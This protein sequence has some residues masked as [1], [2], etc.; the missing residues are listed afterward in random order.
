MNLPNLPMAAVDDLEVLDGPT[1]TAL[2]L[3]P[4]GDQTEPV[5]T[6]C[7]WNIYNTRV[8]C[9]AIG[10][11]LYSGD[12]YETRDEAYKATAAKY[13]RIVEANYVPGRAFFR[14]K[15]AVKEVL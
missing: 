9:C 5:A 1:E 4:T 11:S 10:N 14:V 15:V 12:R 2:D 8:V 6:Y 3:V 7:D 13:G